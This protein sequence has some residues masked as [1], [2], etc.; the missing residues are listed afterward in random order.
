MARFSPYMVRMIHLNNIKDV[1]Y[2][3]QKQ[4]TKSAGIS[5]THFN[6]VLHLDKAI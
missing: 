4:T 3:N 5:K 6:F 2:Q 1:T